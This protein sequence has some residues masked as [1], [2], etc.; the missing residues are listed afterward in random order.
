MTGTLLR[1]A[2]ALV[3]LV[4]VAVVAFIFL[5]LWPASTEVTSV[6]IQWGTV[7]DEEKAGVVALM[8]QERDVFRATFDQRGR[9]I[10]LGLMVMHPMDWERAEHLAETFADRADEVAQPYAEVEPGEDGVRPDV[11]P[12][13][14]YSVRV[15][16]MNDVFTVG[17]TPE[18]EEFTILEWSR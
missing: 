4:A 7:P 5:A 10:S 12:A 15:F 14:R 11:Q 16:S 2:L 6:V 8:E 1:A 9:D 17:K 13:F 3:A 18:P